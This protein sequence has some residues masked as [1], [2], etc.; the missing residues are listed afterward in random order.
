PQNLDNKMTYWTVV[1]RPKAA[2]KA[3]MS[4]HG[5]VEVDKLGFTLEPFIHASSGSP[6]SAGEVTGAPDGSAMLLGWAQAQ[7]LQSL[8]EGFM[9]IPSVER[10]Y[11]NLALK[12]T[13][14]EAGSDSQPLTYVRYRVKNTSAQALR[15]PLFV[16]VRPFQ[17]N[18]PWQFLNQPGG[19]SPIKSL[20]IA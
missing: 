6:S 1:S 14:W 10:T 16:A 4:E 12:V 3:L 18:P 9:P 19:F 8:E 11:D 13:A 17:V 15:G 20:R 5:S 7:M 2:H